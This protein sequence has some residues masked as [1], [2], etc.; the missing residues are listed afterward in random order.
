MV[1]PNIKPEV[2][3]FSRKPDGTVVVVNVSSVKG[4][5][6]GASE[7]RARTAALVTNGVSTPPSSVLDDI[8]MGEVTRFTQVMNVQE[9]GSSMGT[10]SRRYKI[11]VQRPY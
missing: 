6:E 11:K 2:Q 8:E 5:P 1:G 9:K 7:L 10:V 3:S 4:I